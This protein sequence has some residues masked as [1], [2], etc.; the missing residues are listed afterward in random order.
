MS[1]IF[2]IWGCPDSGKTTFAVRLAKAIYDEQ[3]TKVICV[4]ADAVTP[5]LPVL[6][7][8]DNDL[9]SVGYALS[10][11]EI[12]PD[13]VL[14]SLVTT[15]TAKNIGFLG[16]TDGENRYSY[17]EYSKD[18]AAALLDAAA[19]L[20]DVVIV[21]CGSEL[22]EVL[23]FAAVSKADTIF[24]ICKPDL[25]AVSFFSSQMPLYTDQKYR[26][27]EH[28][29]VLSVPEQELYMPIGE[30][31]MHFGCEMHIIPYAP[32]IKRQ[33]LG[34]SIFGKVTKKAWNNAI[35]H[36]AALAVGT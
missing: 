7:P 22:K 32:E 16:F 17:P 9:L 6:F 33:S 8:G 23:A 2:A 31:A 21:D 25:K 11:T 15:D 24:R 14:C 20:A 27:R 3:G 29:T 4:F 1:K 18:K 30:A 28:L 26:L 13:A 36:Y 35:R 10:Q 19:T 12:T 5:A 34:G